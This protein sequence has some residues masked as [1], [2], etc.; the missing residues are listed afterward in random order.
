[1]EKEKESSSSQRSR[2]HPAG[3]G[4]PSEELAYSLEGAR[5]SGPAWHIQVL[6]NVVSVSFTSYF[7]RDS[8]LQVLPQV[9]VAP[10]SSVSLSLTVYSGLSLEKQGCS[11]GRP[12]DT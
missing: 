6:K 10:S 11:S 9:H 1:M 12:T 2:P 4:D 5:S 7:L 8:L 3:F